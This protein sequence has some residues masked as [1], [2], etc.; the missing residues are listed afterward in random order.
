MPCTRTEVSLWFVH[1]DEGEC[2]QNV[3]L[4]ICLKSK[5]TANSFP[6]DYLYQYTIHIFDLDCLIILT[7]IQPD[8]RAFKD[9]IN[10]RYTHMARFV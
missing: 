8:Y 3:I 6:Q 4:P 10:S 7:N 2:Y 9:L 5:K 1:A